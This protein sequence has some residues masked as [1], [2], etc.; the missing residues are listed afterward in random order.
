MRC[1]FL[2]ALAVT[3][4]LIPAKADILYD[5]TWC[6]NFNYQAHW[7]FS[8]AALLTETTTIQAADLITA[9]FSPPPTYTGTITSVTIWT[10]LAS[11][12]PMPDVETD[13]TLGAFG[14]YGWAGAFDNLG[15]YTSEA[16]S[17]LVISETT[18]PEPTSLLLFGIMTCALGLGLRNRLRRL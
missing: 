2:F 14:D 16:G 13:W 15:T 3:T 4:S 1:F 17:V 7:S 10:P 6:G 12:P 18:V 9:S 8:T 5:F 11:S